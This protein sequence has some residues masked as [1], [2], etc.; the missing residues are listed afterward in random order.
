MFLPFTV[1][2]C[3][4][5]CVFSLCVGGGGGGGHA[6]YSL[7]FSGTLN[8]KLKLS[9]RRKLGPSQVLRLQ[10]CPACLRNP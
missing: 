9:F 7:Y 4:C 6:C 3:V 2:A 1:C 10:L 8:R 5:V